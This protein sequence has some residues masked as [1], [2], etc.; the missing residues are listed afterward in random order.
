MEPLARWV[1]QEAPEYWD[2]ETRIAKGHEQNFRVGLN[3]LRSY[4]NQSAAA[5]DGTDYLTLNEDL[6]SWTAAD[7]S[8]QIARRK[9]EVG[10]EAKSQRNYLEGRCV[11]WLR[12]YLEIGKETL[13]RAEPPKDT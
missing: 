2:R 4:Y 1:E 12:R 10:R 13:Q 11:E 5:Y 8:A 9:W 6:S 3:N 7:T